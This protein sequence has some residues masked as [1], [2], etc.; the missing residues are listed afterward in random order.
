MRPLRWHTYPPPP[1]ACVADATAGGP[2]ICVL[3]PGS[4]GRLDESEGHKSGRSH[5]LSGQS[6][7]VL[8]SDLDEPSQLPF[9][10]TW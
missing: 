7:M 5:S 4:F 8:Y 2:W 10:A 6:I 1:A 9:C 3:L